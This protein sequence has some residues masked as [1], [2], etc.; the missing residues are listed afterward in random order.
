MPTKHRPPDELEAFCHSCPEP[1][2]VIAF[3]A[4]LGLRLDF[5]LEAFSPPVY[6]ELSELPAQFHFADASGMSLIYLAGEDGAMENGERLPAHKSRFWAYPGGDAQH[7]ERITQLVAH[8]WSF[9]WRQ[10]SHA[11]QDV[12]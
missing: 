12:A 9:T 5:Q 3:L 11:Q 7:F 10:L 8:R 6:S 1:E 4:Q 2:V